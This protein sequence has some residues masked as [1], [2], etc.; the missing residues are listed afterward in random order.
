MDSI[1]KGQDRTDQA[2]AVQIQK[3]KRGIRSSFVRSIYVDW[4]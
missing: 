3:Y 1:H 2:K 4:K